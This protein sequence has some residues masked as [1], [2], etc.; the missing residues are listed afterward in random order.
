MKT[1]HGAEGV[2]AL[3]ISCSTLHL[4]KLP[5]V[6]LQLTYTTT[7]SDYRTPA[8]TKEKV[9]APCP[10]ITTSLI[11]VPALIPCL[12]FHSSTLFLATLSSKTQLPQSIS[13][14]P[15]A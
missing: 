9:T 2:K 10:P 11:T 15:T 12:T 7:T 1:R 6:Y 8:K 5:S 4:R 13:P 14:S 3:R